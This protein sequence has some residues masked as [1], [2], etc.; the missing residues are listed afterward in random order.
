MNCYTTFFSL[1]LAGAIKSSTNPSMARFPRDIA[2]SVGRPRTGGVAKGAGAAIRSDSRPRPGC[3]LVRSPATSGRTVDATGVSGG[4]MFLLFASADGY[5]CSAAL[6]RP[7]GRSAGTVRTA[8]LRFSA[9]DPAPVV[10]RPYQ[11]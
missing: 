10:L 9:P 11:G 7:V 4:K 1:D 6:P 8:S 5:R 2:R 3:P